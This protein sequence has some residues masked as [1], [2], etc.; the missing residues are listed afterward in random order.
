MPSCGAVVGPCH[1]SP[2]H[3]SPQEGAMLPCRRGLR[4]RRPAHIC[5]R[6]VGFSVGPGMLASFSKGRR[7]SIPSHRGPSARGRPGA[8]PRHGIRRQCSRP[9][10]RDPG[11]DPQPTRS[12]TTLFARASFSGRV[13]KVGIAPLPPG[14][15]GQIGQSPIGGQHNTLIGNTVF[16][17]L[18]DVASSLPPYLAVDQGPGGGCYG[19][20]TQCSA[21]PSLFLGDRLWQIVN[22]REVVLE[23]LR[24]AYPLTK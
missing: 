17:W 12:P 20:T 6:G 21:L 14:A 8:S 11:D 3:V 7:P 10:T 9:L 2:F 4:R 22:G 24:I 19:P 5:C 1:S 16:L 23:A 15:S 13:A 18:S